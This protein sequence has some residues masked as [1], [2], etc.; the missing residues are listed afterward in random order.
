MWCLRAAVAASCSVVRPYIYTQLALTFQKT[1]GYTPPQ[2]DEDCL[3]G[4]VPFPL[5]ET[6]QLGRINLHLSASIARHPP[7]IVAYLSILR[8]HA[9]KVDLGCERYL[10]RDVGVAGAAVNLNAVDAVLVHALRQG[11]ASSCFM[12][13]DGIRTCGGPSIVPFQSDMRRSSPLSRPYE[14]ASIYS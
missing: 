14:H 3:H 12:S 9:R 1:P 13:C 11:L 5:R 8:V 7:T 4:E 6:R 2:L 10:G